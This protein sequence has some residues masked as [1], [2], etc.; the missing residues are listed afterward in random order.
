MK[1]LN[2]FLIAGA[3]I[4]MPLYLK[5]FTQE[6]DPAI[7]LENYISLGEFNTDGNYDHWDFGEWDTRSVS[8][9][10]LNGL[11]ESG[12]PH[13]ARVTDQDIV[14]EPGAVIE[15][16]IK[17][18]A[19][20][21]N[22]V[23]GCYPRIDGSGSLMPGIN[24]AG[25]GTVATQTDGVYHIYRVTLDTADDPKYFGQLT[26]MRFN[27]A[28]NGS[29]GDHFSIDYIR[30]ANAILT[31]APT[32]Y[33]P[34]VDN[35]FNRGLL[36]CNET[37]T[38][39]WPDGAADCFLNPDDNSSGRLAASPIMNASNDWGIARDDSTMPT[40]NTNSPY[41]G[42]Y[43]AFDGNNSILVTNSWPGGDNLDLNLCFRFKDLPPHSGDNYAG[44]L[45]TLPVKAYLMAD[46]DGVHGKVLMLVYD[47]ASQPHFFYSSKTINSNVWYYLGFSASNNILKVIVGNEDEGYETSISSAT[48][49]L[50]PSV[51]VPF[52]NVIIGSDYFGPTR[53]FHG[54]M[55][56][57]RWG[58][59]IPEPFY[60]S[61]I[62]YSLLFIIRK[63]INN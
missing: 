31:N 17:F 23:I 59:V 3:F 47:A 26:S 8:G 50:T 4:L 10:S 1:K 14:F 62:I 46:D 60:L 11:N 2:L 36:H 45:W 13:M 52:Y 55:D 9:G 35:E 12:W 58:V 16:R 6:L 5:A 53:L 15:A 41:G 63:S 24:L 30:V 29:V 44:L 7:P 32:P 51:S 37:I 33:P 42:D 43:L 40:L 61:F 49:L 57:V 27:P 39:L 54:D 18:D 28:D 22:G 56:E 20:T 38:N 25:G 21:G 48:G 19:G 34:Y